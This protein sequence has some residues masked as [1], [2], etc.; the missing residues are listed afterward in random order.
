MM[1]YGPVR[2]VREPPQRRNRRSIRLQ[3][4]DYRQSG[5]YFVTVCTQ[6]RMCLF[7]DIT[8]NK[9]VL[10][11]AGQVARQCWNDI[12]CHFPHVELDACVIMPNHIHGIIVITDVTVGAN[13]RAKNLS[14]LQ[15]KQR[16]RG[17]S[18]TIGSMV[19]GFKIGVTKWMRQNM[20][21]EHVWQRGFYEHIIRNEVELNRTRKYITENPERWAMDREN[22]N[23]PNRTVGAKKF[24]PLQPNN[25][26]GEVGYELGKETPRR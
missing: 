12:P 5:A 18:K 13:V 9:M 1:R 16:P 7:G 14:P 4:Y 26:F 22:F 3:G 17:T 11:N 21:V 2:A 23:T 25:D 6:N 8:D 20:S 15:P 10:N 24:S 19:R